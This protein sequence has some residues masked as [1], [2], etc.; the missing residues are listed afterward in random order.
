MYME[1]REELEQELQQ[2]LQWVQYRQEMLD[3]MEGKLLQMRELAQKAK[4]ENLTAVELEELNVKINN[5]A[6]HVRALDWESRRT[7]Y[8][9]ILE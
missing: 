1:E 6:A 3:I 4:Q 8:G 7:E 9:K 5:L 2:E